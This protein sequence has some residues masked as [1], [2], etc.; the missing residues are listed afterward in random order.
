M[1]RLDSVA[2]AF[3]AIVV[4]WSAG[5]VIRGSGS[6]F[7]HRTPLDQDA[8]RRQIERLDGVTGVDDFH[9]WQICSQITVATTHVETDADTM[10]DAETITRDIH[11]VLADADVD[12]ATVELCPGFGDRET[13]LNH[14]RH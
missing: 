12:H 8:I 10:A 3:I 5:R 14:H 11:T 13:H 7:L 6:I 4:I 9:A 2:A 1:T